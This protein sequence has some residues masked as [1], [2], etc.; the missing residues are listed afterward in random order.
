MSVHVRIRNGLQPDN[1]SGLGGATE[2]DL[3]G[4]TGDLIAN[5]NGGIPDVAG[6]QLLVHEAGSPD[7]EVIVDQGVVYIPND[8]FD[9]TDS[10]SI[11]F[12][13]AVVGGT[14]GSRTLAISSN[15]SGQTRIDIV[16]V[17]ID[18]GAE[19][20]EFAS[21]IA[22][23]VVIEGTP[24]A[25]VPATPAFRV[26]LAEV[27]VANG[28][29]EITDANIND[30]REQLRIFSRFLTP[31]VTNVTSDTTPNPNADFFDQYNLLALAGD[32]VVAAP[33]GTPVNGQKLVLRIKDNGTARAL[34]FNSIYREIGVVLPTTTTANK[35]MYIGCI[36]NSADS[37]WDV[38]AVSE[39]F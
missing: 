3:R 26:K 36:Y 12:W 32:A 21:N 24:G 29:T 11:R 9:Y 1:Y 28:A 4:D 16:C 13:E 25:G 5:Q 2:G 14:S 23:L 30:T 33:D 15:S 22:E 7:M 8:S 20:D 38:V 39:E 17:E 34:S 10:D 37:K 27:T 31:S 18:P 19:P 35:T 6:G